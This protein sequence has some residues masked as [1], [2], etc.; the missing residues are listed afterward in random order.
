[1]KNLSFRYLAV[2]IP[3]IVAF[4]VA[5]AQGE[6]IL[7]D[8]NSGNLN[9][10]SM[11]KK[12]KNSP[13]EDPAPPAPEISTK[14]IRQFDK[15]FKTTSNERWYTIGNGQ[16]AEFEKDGITTKVFF[17]QKGVWQAMVRYYQEDKLPFYVKEMVRTS[18]YDFDIVT[19][20][21]VSAC[22]KIAYLVKMDGKNYIKTIRVVDGEMD[23]YESFRKSVK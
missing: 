20:I 19:V 22:N 18:Y 12:V 6:K 23:E 5:I 14:A 15:Q 7:T 1:M 10:Y 13:T 2:I 4:N 11:G 9:D 3:A 17:S 16:V 21:E 8:A